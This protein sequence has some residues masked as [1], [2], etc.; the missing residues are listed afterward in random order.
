ML[1]LRSTNAGIGVSH[2]SVPVTTCFTSR[3]PL[4]FSWQSSCI[5]RDMHVRCQQQEVAQVST[6]T[7][8]D[9]AL[10]NFSF[11]REL[12]GGLLTISPLQRD[13]LEETTDLMTAAFADSDS[14]KLSMYSKFLRRQISSYLKSHMAMIPNTVVLTA[15]WRPAHIS[16]S[17]YHGASNSASAREG[18]SGSDDDTASQ[19]RVTE[20]S[21]RPYD[22]ASER[23]LVDGGLASS[24]TGGLN[25]VQGPQLWGAA[26]ISLNARTR[27]RHLTLNPPDNEPYLCNMAVAIRHRR[28]GVAKLL[29]QS[30]EQVSNIAG[31]KRMYLHLRLQDN[32]PS[33]LYNKAGFKAV[34]EDPWIVEVFGMDRCYLMLKEL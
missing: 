2:S 4:P 7:T 19:A 14:T 12:D 6:N 23:P 10:L 26:E 25:S 32:V 21:G 20:P 16:C 24:S 3:Q 15:V 31:K 29:L 27:E 9:T 8:I 5:T 11:Q 34:E 33:M 22:N 13:W 30:A 18:G 28:K 17:T 1:S